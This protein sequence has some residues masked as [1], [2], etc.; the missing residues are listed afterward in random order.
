MKA[1]STVVEAEVIWVFITRSCSCW[2]R[3]RVWSRVRGPLLLFFVRR[4]LK[5][6]C[7]LPL[8]QNSWRI[9]GVTC[10]ADTHWSSAGEYPSHLTLYCLSPVRG[11]SLNSNTFS[12]SHLSFSTGPGFSSLRPGNSLSLLG[13]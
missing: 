8:T 2:I 10:D 3:A 4:R 6:S 5:V 7:R 13:V 1:D 9:S 12:T 11:A